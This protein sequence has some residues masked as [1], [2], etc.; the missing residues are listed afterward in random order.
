LGLFFYS[1]LTKNGDG[2]I[3]AADG[4]NVVQ[5]ANYIPAIL[6]TKMLIKTA[7]LMPMMRCQL[8]IPPFPQITYGF[9]LAIGMERI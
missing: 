7:K 8:V 6:N 1:R 2:I 9:T 5:L 4:Y 3:N